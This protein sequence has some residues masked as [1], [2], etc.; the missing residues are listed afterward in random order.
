MRTVYANVLTQSSE[1]DDP[2]EYR[3]PLALKKQRPSGTNSPAEPIIKAEANGTI[4]T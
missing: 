3:F 2:E 4:S 1:E